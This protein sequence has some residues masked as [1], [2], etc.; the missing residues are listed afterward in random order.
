MNLIFKIKNV[1]SAEFAVYH[2]GQ[3]RNYFFSYKEALFEII[4]FSLTE[5]LI[6]DTLHTVK[7]LWYPYAG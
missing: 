5:S 1:T 7:F 2:Q 3:R 6:R 4:S